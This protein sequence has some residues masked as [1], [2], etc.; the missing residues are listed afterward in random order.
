VTEVSFAHKSC[1]YLIKNG[2]KSDIV[3]HYYNYL[4]F[5]ILIYFKM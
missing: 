3:K 4:L 2:K 5:S 1:I